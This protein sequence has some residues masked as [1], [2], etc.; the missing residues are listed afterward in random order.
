MSE[1]AAWSGRPHGQGAEQQIIMTIGRTG[2]AIIRSYPG[3][4]GLQLHS[5]ARLLDFHC[6]S[7]ARRRQSA[8]VATTGDDATGLL[9][10]SCFHTSHAEGP[11][12]AGEDTPPLAP[13]N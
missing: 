10:P 2:V 6:A 11:R 4:R 1:P 9:C 8:L 3:W 5:L 12:D 13:A 7:C